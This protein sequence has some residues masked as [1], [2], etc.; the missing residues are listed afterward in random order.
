MSEE[1]EIRD[2]VVALLKAQESGQDVSELLPSPEGFPAKETADAPAQTPEQ[3]LASALAR[4]LAFVRTQSRASQLVTPSDWAEAGLVPEFLDPEDVETTVYD[5]LMAYKEACDLDESLGDRSK[6]PAEAA[7][8]ANTRPGAYPESAVQRNPH[9]A[10]AFSSSPGRPVGLS[11]FKHRKAEGS[12]D[13]A[14]ETRNP[15]RTSNRFAD[16]QAP[17]GTLTANAMPAEDPTAS[18]HSQA[19]TAAGKE[20]EVNAADAS[21]QAAAAGPI[22]LETVEE[23]GSESPSTQSPDSAPDAFAD[24]RGIRLLMGAHSYYLYDEAAM[25]DTYARWA[26]L[27]AEDDPVATFLECVRDESRT[28]PRPLAR[29]NLANPPFRMDA[30]AVEAAWRTACDQGRADDVQRIEA[31]NGA[32][33]FYSTDYLSPARARSLAQYDAVERAFNV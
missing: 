4:A 13:V 28:Y 16:A 23:Q 33:Y 8:N 30:E 29:T 24:C 6:V 22:P 14:G 5:R 31:T 20:P 15:S 27:A 7:A 26:F 11:G 21:T 19:D 1:D 17:D 32:V 10:S 25:T 3:A 18:A 12:K 2:A 9:A